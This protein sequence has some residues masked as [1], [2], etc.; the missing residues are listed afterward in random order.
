[1]PSTKSTYIGG[2][3]LVNARRWQLIASVATYSKSSSTAATVSG[4]GSLYWWNPT[5]NHSI[6]GWT[7][8]ASNVAYTA[9]Y[10]ATSKTSPG[11]FGITISYTPAAGQPAP[12]PNSAPVTLTNGAIALS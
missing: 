11:T 7:L 4:S 5:L 2:L 10:T 12:L 8:A 9:S 6:G 1:V 3:T